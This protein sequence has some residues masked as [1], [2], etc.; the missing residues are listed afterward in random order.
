MDFIPG[1]PGELTEMSG[2]Q[3]VP[4]PLVMLL[5]AAGMWALHRWVPLGHLIRTPWNY[6]AV[7][8]AALGRAL[9]LAAGAR[10]RGART[11]LDPSKPKQASCLVTEGVFQLS[12]NPMYLGLVL[13]LMAW[14]VWLGTVSPWL[15]PPL[16]VVVIS[17][18]HIVPE[19]RALEE[20]FG[21][22]YLA[23]RH[24]VRRW[25]GRSVV[26]AMPRS[27]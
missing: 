12:R 21:E 11:T 22:R 9:T 14:A 8:P 17:L 1:H 19:E 20:L 18:A 26:T 24:S 27:D 15:I 6:L 5:A 10:F 3:R 2:L 7:L 23:Y 13:L 4:P 25:I 16:F